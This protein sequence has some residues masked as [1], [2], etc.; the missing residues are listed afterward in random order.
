VN[1]IT[2][3][4]VAVGNLN[5]DVVLFTDTVPQAGMTILARDLQIRPGGA[6]VNYAVTVSQYGHEAYIVT[7]ASS[8]EITRNILEE[9]KQYGVKTDYVK[10]TEGSPGIVLIIVDKSGERTMIKYP[11]VNEE[12][13][14]S[15]LAGELLRKAHVVHVASVKPDVAVGIVELA[16]SEGAVTSLDPGGYMANWSIEMF[17]KTMRHIH[18]LFINESDFCKYLKDAGLSRVFKYG[19]STLVV[20]RGSKGAVVLT[21]SECY[22]GCAEPIKK[23]V[24]TTGAGDAFDALFNAKY[25][26]SKDLGLSLVY[27]LAAG[28]LKTGF[29]SSFM[30]WNSKLF[31]FQ[32]KKVVVERV[33]CSE[34]VLCTE[35]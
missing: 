22:S 27:A 14:P 32:L 8:H 19:L 28:A 34:V 33:E 3:T 1:R 10:F 15:D 5:I 11:G 20:K 18:V 23:P 2:Y 30:K 9:V 21:Q 13:N 24:D 17:L 29:K 12:L 31:N 25:I 6:A 26:E 4:H 7:R 16:S 35:N